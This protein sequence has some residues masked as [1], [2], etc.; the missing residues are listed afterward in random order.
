MGSLAGTP[1]GSNASGSEQD[2]RQVSAGVGALLVFISAMVLIGWCLDVALFRDLLA[3]QSPMKANTALGFLLAGGSLWLLS[4]GSVSECSRRRLGVLCALVVLVLG[5]LTAA[6]YAF[7][8]DLGVDSL[9]IPRSLGDAGPVRMAPTTALGFLFSGASLLVLERRPLGLVSL[10]VA[11]SLVPLAVSMLVLLG[12]LY[13]AQPLCRLGGARAMAME[14]AMAFAVLAAGVIVSRPRGWISLLASETP[15]GTAVRLMVPTVLLAVPL[16]FWLRQVGERAGLF[17]TESGVALMVLACML[18]LSGFLVWSAG[19][20]NRA[21]AERRRIEAV[22]WQQERRLG[23]LMSN[24]PGMVYSCRND[25][26]W[27]MTFVSEGARDLLGYT[28]DQLVGNRVVSYAELIHPAD[29]NEVWRQVQEG[30]G[31]RRAFHAVYRVRTGSGE[32]RWVQE[33]GRGI[34]DEEGNL[35]G[36][37]GFVT[38]VTARNRAERLLRESNVRFEAVFQ[39][40][41]VGIALVAPDGRW[42]L[43]NRKLCQVMGYSEEELMGRTFQSITH[44]EDIETDLE[45]VRRM[46]ARE[47][48]TYSIEKRYLRKDGCAFWARLTASLTWTPEGRP[49]YFISVVE[50]VDA[51]RRA[52][53]ALR[54]SEADLKEARRLAGLG[55]WDWD[56]RTG[57]SAWSEEVYRLHGL[58]PA[59]PPLPYSEI[60]RYFL[61]ESW[62]RLSAAMEYCIATGTGY[63][64]DVEVVGGEGRTRWITARGAAVRDADGRV[65]RLRGTVQ[66]ITERKRTEEMLRALNRHLEGLQEALRRLATSRTQEEIMAVALATARQLAGADGTAFILREGDNC[67]YAGEEA[68]APLWRGQVF[69]ATSCASGR[70]MLTQ[71]PVAVQDVYSEPG[72]SADVYRPTFVR[73][74]AIVPI[75]AAETVGAIGS[76]WAEPHRAGAEEIALL[77]SLADGVAI[78]MDNVRSYDLLEQRVHERT[79]ELRAANQELDA[80]AY[81]VSH[82]LRAPL[83]AMGGFSQAL[84]ED[85]GDSLPAEGRAYLAEIIEGSHRMG[86]LIDGLL[87]LSRGTRGELRRDRVDIAGLACRI[88]GELQ[89]AEPDRRAEWDVEPGLAVRGDQRM[90]EVVLTNLLDNAWK[91]TGTCPAPRIRVYGEHSDS[92][93]VFC[94]TDNGAGFDPRFSEKLFQPFQRLHRQDEFPGIGIGLATAKRILTRHGGTIAAESTPGQATTFRCRLP[95]GGTEGKEVD[96]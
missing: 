34:F 33:Q 39:Q 43:V 50:D 58:D 18:L 83:R 32:E 10:P 52:E 24:L 95:R 40:A 1:M 20:L 93:Y 77:A 25:P 56:L 45:Q 19:S 49:D 31:Q 78:A 36:L 68:I 13:G 6:E 26:S 7:A 91:Y 44:P 37:E 72:L 73:S 3:R 94:V 48:D 60:R 89:A 21:E 61:P 87:C 86:E 76:Y 22:R 67:H 63:E 41:A 5:L 57:R 51:R 47:I 79:D 90:L 15:G 23:A 17:D 14:T 42:L 66:D 92:E 75:R 4:S 80:F 38:D 82:D 70:A 71:A 30:V 16:L 28:A 27:T 85:F 8:W 62:E 29:R 96:A 59:L 35:L 74:L 55:N 46:L 12:Y 69:P 2:L 84:V 88:L 53:D 11:F 64:C 81:A 65:V 9:F 54:A